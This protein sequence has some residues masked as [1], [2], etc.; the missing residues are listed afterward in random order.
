[1]VILAGT[2]TQ[3]SLAQSRDTVLTL[4]SEVFANTRSL[5][6]LLP[7]GYHDPANAGKH[8]PVFYFTDGVAAWHGWGVPEVAD[9]LWR[10]G[11]IPEYLFVGID[12]GGSTIETTAPARD[13]ASE[14]LPYSDPTWT[15]SPPE[16]RGDRFP[17]FLFT[18][19][20]PLV[21]ERFRVD[22]D[23]KATGL[24]GDSYAGAATLY[25]GMRHA[26]RLGLLLIESPSLHIGDRRLLADAA[27][28]TNWPGVVYLGV[29][30]A[31]GD[32]PAIRQDMVRS[33][34]RLEETVRLQAPETRVGLLVVEGGTHWY[35]AWRARLPRAL[36]F[37]LAARPLEPGG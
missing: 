21:A 9:S 2:P 7:P 10:E 31:E 16:P 33:V 11:V 34:R 3:V 37:L 36:A 13:R 25:T 30:T 26:D 14:Y 19:V 28:T 6:V 4:S 5:R 27:S 12:N 18:E 15:N 17:T 24:A 23:P 29:G 1:M 8:Y 22:P 20:M 32:T 35:T